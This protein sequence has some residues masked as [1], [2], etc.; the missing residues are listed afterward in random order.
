MRAAVTLL[1]VVGFA[2]TGHAA[3]PVD[4]R[5]QVYP[6]LHDRCFRCHQGADAKS[7]VRLD[8]RAEVL[9]RTRPA[10][11][12]RDP[13]LVALVSSAEECRMMPPTGKRLTANEG[14]RLRDCI[15]QGAKWDD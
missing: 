13:L 5:K 6:L 3:D 11:G 10:K 4:F 8:L 14:Q 1:A 7:G 9:P 15:E 12:E 2:A